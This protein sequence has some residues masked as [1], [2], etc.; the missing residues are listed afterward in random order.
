MQG[1]VLSCLY[2]IGLQSHQKSFLIKTLLVLVILWSW[3]R[4]VGWKKPNISESHD[5]KQAKLLSFQDE[6]LKE[7][8]LNLEIHVL[9]YEYGTHHSLPCS[10][11]G[12]NVWCIALEMLSMSHFTQIS[13]LK[14]FRNVFEGNRLH[15]KP[16]LNVLTW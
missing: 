16:R 12:V 7:G 9:F 6:D 3:E 10:F 11:G 14:G 4:R 2:S 13:A 5:G 1:T 8:A 15:I